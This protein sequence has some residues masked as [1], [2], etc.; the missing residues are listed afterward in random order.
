M[1]G[2]WEYAEPISQIMSTVTAR[3]RLNNPCWVWRQFDYESSRQ[4]LLGLEVIYQSGYPI[5]LSYCE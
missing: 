3:K 4:G 2:Q 5:L 1:L